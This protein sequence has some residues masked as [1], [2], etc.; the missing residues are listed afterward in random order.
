MPLWRFACSRCAHCQLPRTTGKSCKVPSRLLILINTHESPCKRRSER[1]QG[2]SLYPYSLFVCRRTAALYARYSPKKLRRFTRAKFRKS[3]DNLLEN[4][5]AVSVWNVRVPPPF[6]GLTAFS[7]LFLF[8][9]ALSRNSQI[10]CLPTERLISM[11]RVQDQSA[12]IK[13]GVYNLRKWNTKNVI[14]ACSSI[15]QTVS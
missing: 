7:C 2:L 8:K 14:C 12:V 11:N 5:N 3:R 1:L 10:R 13:L 6:R 9:P 4:F 15:E